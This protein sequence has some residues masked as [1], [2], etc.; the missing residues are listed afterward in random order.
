[1]YYM[2]K[3]IYCQILV[4]VADSWAAARAIAGNR[5]IITAKPKNHC[6]QDIPSSKTNQTQNKPAYMVS[7][8]P[9]AVS[10]KITL[11]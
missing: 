7:A 10:L 3:S 4:L 8:R 5:D 2:P 1:M 9:Q 11:P 6:T